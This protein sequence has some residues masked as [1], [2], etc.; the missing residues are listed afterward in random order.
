M[1]GLIKNTESKTSGV[2]IKYKI[3]EISADG[4]FQKIL[5]PTFR[6]DF[7]S[8]FYNAIYL[9]AENKLDGN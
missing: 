9:T 5:L 1:Y 4:N 3:L 6:S 8:H 7:Y 2:N